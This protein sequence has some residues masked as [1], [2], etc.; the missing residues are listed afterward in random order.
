[1]TIEK[2]FQN[3]ISEADLAS[4]VEDLLNLYRWRWVHFRPAQSERG[5]RTPIRGGG[6]DGFKGKGLPDYIAV[7]ASRLLFI[8]LKSEKGKLSK[9][10]MAKLLINL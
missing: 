3:I 5:W 9:A 2:D 4:Y 8:E 10:Q 6:P 7:K 1:M